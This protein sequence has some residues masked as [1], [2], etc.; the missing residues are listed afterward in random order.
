MLLFLTRSVV[1]AVRTFNDTV[2]NR[3][4][5]TIPTEIGF[6]T[7]LD[8]LDLSDNSLNGKI[9]PELYMLKFLRNLL[10]GKYM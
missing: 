2:N 6:L 10:L 3:L 1:V 7:F 5:G 9:P 4:T 8:I